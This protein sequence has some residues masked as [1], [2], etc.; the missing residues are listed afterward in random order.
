MRKLGIREEI[1]IGSR[2]ISR[3]TRK[4]LPWE[5]STGGHK[6]SEKYIDGCKEI[7]EYI[8][9]N[10]DVNKS[11]LLWNCLLK[12]IETK[13]N[14]YYDLGDL[15]EG[16]YSYF[17]YSSRR[18]TFEATDSIDL[19]N[20]QWLVNRDGEFV[21]AQHVTREE[22]S[23]HYD[24]D[25]QCAEDLMDFL[26]ISDEDDDE[27]D[28]DRY[29]NL[30]DA[31][32]DK[33]DKYN[34]IAATLKANNIDLE[35]LSEI[36]ADYNRNREETRLVDVTHHTDVQ[37]QEE[38]QNS[39][40][41]EDTVDIDTLLEPVSEEPEQKKPDRVS[42][43]KARVIKDILQKVTNT[44]QQEDQS[45]T[46]SEEVEDS[47]EYMPSPV[48]YSKMIDRA[49]QKNANELSKI[50]HYQELQEKAL[51]CH[52][53][54]FGWFKTLLEMECLSS[55]TNSMSNREV[56]IS[57]A[58]VER[59]EGTK[60]TLVLHYPNRYIP[61]FMEDLTDIPLVLHYDDSTR[62]L[63]IEVANIRSYTLRVK[64][65]SNVSIEGVDLKS[66]RSATIDAKSPVFLLDELKKKLNALEF[67]DDFSMQLNLTQRIEFVFG[68]PGTGKT[69]YLARNVILP[70][71][72]ENPN[73]KVL[74]LTPTNK[75][76][77]VLV[78]RIME[79][80]GK[81]TSYEK[82]LVRF[83]TTGDESIEESPV[84]RDKTFDLRSEPRSVTVTT[85]A[86]FP[87]DFF[88]PQGERMFLD[89]INWD[90]III[91]EASMIPL[92]N[93]VYPLYKKTPRKFIIAGDPFQIE[94]ITAV[95]LWKNENI[96]TMV[97]LQS[98]VNPTT[99]PH[100]YKVDLLT[101]QYRSVPTIGNVFSGFAYGGILRHYRS[102]QTQRRLN[103]SDGIKTINILK[104]P[105]SKYESIYKSKRLN[106]SSSFHIYSA[107]FTFEYIE[108][109][110][111]ELSRSNPEEQ[112]KIGIIAPYRAQAEI[113]DNLLA[114]SALPKSIDV[115]VGTIHGFQGDECDIIFAVL[116]T[117]PSLTS[118]KE[119]FLNKLNIINVSISRARDYLFIVMP[120]DDTENISNLKLVKRVEALVKKSS[121]WKEYKT[122]DLERSLF[123]DQHYIE[124]N[125]FSTSHHS[126]NV[127]GL[128]EQ[129]YEIRVDEEAV[130]I[131]IHRQSLTPR[132]IQTDT[133]INEKAETIEES[134]T[135]KEEQI[136]KQPVEEKTDDNP[137]PKQLQ[138]AAYKVQVTGKYAGEYYLVPY[139]GKIKTY[140]QK[141]VTAMFIPMVRNGKERL[142][143]VSVIE[144]DHLIFVTKD[145]LKA[146]EKDLLD[147]IT[148]SKT[149]YG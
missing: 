18:R 125:S 113:I 112:F 28:E 66:V 134:N 118:S 130:D 40:T 59:E 109:L 48:D 24:T 12:I 97:K 51:S 91:D 88:M 43:K 5:R 41:D 128:P 56:S 21:S 9:E 85:I 23:E 95:D 31:Q 135:T 92:V 79:T 78:K 10:E 16:T 11:I 103:I 58:K 141:K 110:G 119:M 60:R 57:F 25:S 87:Y 72:A 129:K 17:Y 108:Y 19:K 22:L 8:V 37:V 49:E 45:Q 70:I 121:S 148:L 76:A 35:E 138:K 15:L 140:T 115:Q 74:V 53:Y 101:T 55:N 90:Y 94:P 1:E 39:S 61:A 29:D 83:G 30:T 100:K 6:Y 73:C 20:K 3:A 137:V 96:Y 14:R 44:E 27:E 42:R 127:Y 2:E 149:Y 7:L 84:Y 131:Q 86:R 145:T 54:S 98:F 139:N 116:N 75:A 146:Y 124:N 52:K 105:V 32:R 38:P 111:K 80:S 142:V 69:T 147:T 89:A 143:S 122:P 132:I 13:C 64:L 99:I 36:L 33:I 47:D 117:P 136:E 133:I 50:F 77:D 46:D 102:E 104:Y 106:K 93:I 26:E 126:V 34:L 71:M 114:S 67:A 63:P 107:I 81:D 123:G 65:K 120:D 82:W 68:P 144:E 62:T 4:D